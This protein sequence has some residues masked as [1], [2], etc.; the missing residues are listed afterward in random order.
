MTM[1]DAVID[2][3]VL[4]RAGA[5]GREL[6]RHTIAQLL[7]EYEADRAHGEDGREVVGE[8]PE[9]TGDARVD[10]ALGALAEHLA[11]RDG[12]PVP[13]WVDEPGRHAGGWL[14]SEL[15]AFQSLAEKETP[16]AFRRHGVLITL[17]ALARA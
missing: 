11:I 15:P 6:W 14:V 7:D 16:A 17:G 4:L 12:W 5:N 2:A 1:V 3:T 13:A 9:L 10:A 8:R